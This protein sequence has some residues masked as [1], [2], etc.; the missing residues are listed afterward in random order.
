[1]WPHIDTKF[2]QFFLKLLVFLDD[3]LVD[4]RVT[5]QYFSQVKFDFFSWVVI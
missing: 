4:A 2:L 5:L 1:M 3:A